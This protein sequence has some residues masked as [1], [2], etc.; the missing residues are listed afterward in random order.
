MS[1]SDP[2]MSSENDNSVGSDDINDA[3]T[4]NSMDSEAH[5]VSTESSNEEASTVTEH[6]SIK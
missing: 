1:G 6:Q 2:E 4:D 5:T 3:N